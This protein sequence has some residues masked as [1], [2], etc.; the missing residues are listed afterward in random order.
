LDTIVEA[1][2]LIAPELAR[3]RLEYSRLVVAQRAEEHRELSSAIVDAARAL[4]DAIV[5]QREYLNQARLDGVAYSLFRPLPTDQFGNLDQ[6]YTPLLKVIRDAT[7]LGHVGADKIPAWKSIDIAY[8][9]NG[10]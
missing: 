10:N 5:A 7:D 3:S 4:G 6:E 9:Q 1:L 2:R 8:L